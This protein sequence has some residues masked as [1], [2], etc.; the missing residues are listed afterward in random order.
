MILRVRNHEAGTAERIHFDSASAPNGLI[1]SIRSLLETSSI[2]QFL[3]VHMFTH[4]VEILD[5]LEKFNGLYFCKF[6]VAMGLF[7][8]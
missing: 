2:K 3:T 1:V 7:I 6:P 4:T 5:V 8:A